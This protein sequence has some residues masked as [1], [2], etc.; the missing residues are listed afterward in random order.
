MSAHASSWCNSHPLSHT[1]IHTNNIATAVFNTVLCACY[2]CV[3]WEQWPHSLLYKLCTRPGV[4]T[5]LQSQSHCSEWTNQVHQEHTECAPP[6]LR[7]PINISLFIS[8]KRTIWI[9]HLVLS[10]LPLPWP[11]KKS[12]W[13]TKHWACWYIL[14][15]GA[16]I[17]V[18][19]TDTSYKELP[20]SSQG[21]LK[22]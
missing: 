11:S 18:W 4:S 9:C 6:V 7:K 21:V 5:Q 8:K 3:L 10:S 13:F 16:E 15:W 2:L 20:I 12:L 1:S 22:A 19:H 14:R 17:Q